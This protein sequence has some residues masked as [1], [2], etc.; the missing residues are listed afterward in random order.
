MA[1]IRWLLASA[2]WLVDAFAIAQAG[3]AIHPV[4]FRARSSIACESDDDDKK[5]ELV[6]YTIDGG[7]GV[8]YSSAIRPN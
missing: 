1:H 8:S 7:G 4:G 3:S 2:A 5:S 6:R